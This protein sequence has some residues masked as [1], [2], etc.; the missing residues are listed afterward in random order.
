L[1]E[2]CT[3]A[4]PPRFL[5]PR[6]GWYKT[7][8]LTLFLACNGVSSDDVSDDTA[9]LNA[10]TF[11]QDIHPVLAANC[12]GC[13]RDGGM[14]SG[15]Q[16]NDGE[17][18]QLLA[19]AIAGAVNAQRMPPFYASEDECEN[20]WGF[21]HDPRLDEEAIGLINDWA[22]AGGPIGDPD[23]PAPLPELPS[24]DLEDASK[25]YPAGQYTTSPSD[26]V[27]DEFV[28]FSID[29][30][31]TEEKWLTAYQVLPQDTEVVHHVLV[32]I[33]NDGTSAG[34]VDENG[35]YPCF[36]GFGEVNATF[37]GGYVPG[38]AP[39]TLPKHSGY[40]LKPGARMV[41][42][43][44]Y[45][46]ADE[47]RQDG[48]GVAVKY[49]EST[50]VQQAFVRLVG[51]ANGPG[52][53]GQGLQDEEFLIPAG[54]TDHTETMMF[55]AW[56]NQVRETR[57][58]LIAN[59]MHYVGQDMKVWVEGD[60]GESCLLHTPNWDFDWQQF[61]FYDAAADNAPILSPEDEL[62]LECTFDN[63]LDNPAVQ[64]ALAESGLSDPIDVGLGEGSLDEMC[65]VVMGEVFDVP[66][67][68][69]QEEATGSLEM[70]VGSSHFGFVNDCSGPVS[71]GPSDGLGGCGLDVLDYLYTVETSFTDDTISFSVVGLPAD[72]I[73]G[74]LADD[75]S[76]DVSGSV[77]G[78]DIRFVGAV[79]PD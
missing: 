64:K 70:T 9:D 67:V 34:Q 59:H 8:V 24:T 15:L 65:L 37:I 10:P 68:H 3:E 50:P 43:M 76:F 14:N 39:T 26:V 31:L 55:K 71:Y 18:A 11:H 6:G 30:G 79:T 22:D 42:Q 38:A 52:E 1:T 73:S 57:L 5:T 54:A 12:S 51:N 60:D 29:L 45:H 20:P 13:H 33:D 75:G 36:G 7:Q 17:T 46:G 62:W 25:H 2:S 32:G 78:G 16:F 48:T 74:D 41:L 77:A 28:C 23:S 35:L 21:V 56:A 53:N 4:P 58:F 19:G 27:E 66:L 69:E 72:V 47:A 40:R 61:Y 49:A 44:H 63:S